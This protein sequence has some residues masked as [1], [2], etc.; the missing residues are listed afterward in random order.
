MR[1]H[2]CDEMD[3]IAGFSAGG[4]IVHLGLRLELGKDTFLGT[5]SIV[6]AQYLFGREWLVGNNQL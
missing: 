4:H 5:P 6:E 2:G 1:Q 3:L